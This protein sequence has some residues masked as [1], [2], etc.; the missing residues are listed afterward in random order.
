MK[1]ILGFD[2]NPLISGLMWA[3]EETIK[4]MVGESVDNEKIEDLQADHDCHL[5]ELGEGHCENSIH[6]EF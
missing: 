2:D 4:A 5:D 1:N 3:T 6:K